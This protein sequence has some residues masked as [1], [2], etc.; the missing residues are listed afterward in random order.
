MNAS[1][2]LRP[3]IKR[4]ILISEDLSVERREITALGEPRRSVIQDVHRYAS[5]RR[6][7]TFKGLNLKVLQI[8]MTPPTH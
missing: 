8:D 3:P 1:L 4:F 6:G 2:R 5:E 7:N